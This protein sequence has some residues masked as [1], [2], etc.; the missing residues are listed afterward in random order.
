MMS[1]RK[2]KIIHMGAAEVMELIEVTKGVLDGKLHARLKDILETFLWM[3]AE[4]EKKKATL[5]RIRK[6]FSINTKKTEKTR[7]VV[8]GGAP[9]PPNEAEEKSGEQP[10]KEKPKPK[11]KGHGRN[12][13]DDYKGA[14]KI[15]T[16][17]DSL[18]S[19]DPCPKC[20]TGKVYVM[21]EPRKLVR[22]KGQAPIDATVY[23]FERLR[24][25]VCN[26]VFVAK[27]PEDIDIG[28]K[29]YDETAASTIGLLK[30]GSGLP[31]YRLEKLMKSFKIPLPTSTQWD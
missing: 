12:S 14:P 25:N 10:E 23:E 7:D 4:L 11:P 15:Q 16:P 6:V 31:F 27:A 19:G 30:Y 26:E 3:M 28:D 8:P 9:S 22:I 18:K 5:A 2:P 20:E 13:A 17:H 1:R 29:K 21:A 24:C